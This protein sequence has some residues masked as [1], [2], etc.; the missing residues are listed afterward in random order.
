M[1]KLHFLKSMIVKETDTK[2]KR[3][4]FLLAVIFCLM[5]IGIGLYFYFSGKG[6]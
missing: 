3:R 6:I 1:C 5:G 4:Y 2:V